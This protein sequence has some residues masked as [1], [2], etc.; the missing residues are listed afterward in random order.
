MLLNRG[1]S[2][3]A[4]AGKCPET[5]KKLTNEVLGKK[6]SKK[7]HTASEDQHQAALWVTQY[8]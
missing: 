4:L 3:K 5:A 7:L 8:L 6:K 2:F 1:L